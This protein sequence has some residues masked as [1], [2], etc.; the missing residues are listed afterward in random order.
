VQA[1][2]TPDRGNQFYVASAHATGEVKDQKDQA[3]DKSRYSGAS[4]LMPTSQREMEQ[5]TEKN[6]RTG[7]EIWHPATFNVKD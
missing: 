3:A 6:S 2:E 5:K 4:Q 7:K 1:A